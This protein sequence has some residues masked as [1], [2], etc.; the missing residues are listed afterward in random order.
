MKE[1]V[2]IVELKVKVKNLEKGIDR[3]KEDVKSDMN[4]LESKLDDIK[5]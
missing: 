1:A 4:K 5:K 3:F 2:D